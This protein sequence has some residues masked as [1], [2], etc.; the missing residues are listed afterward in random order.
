R[1]DLGRLAV[2]AARWQ[3]K[4]QARRNGFGKLRGDEPVLVLKAGPS[5]LTERGGDRRLEIGRHGDRRAKRSGE[6]TD[7]LSGLLVIERGV[8]QHCGQLGSGDLKLALQHLLVLA[9]RRGRR[10]RLDKVTSGSVQ[11]D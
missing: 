10:A 11:L 9:R 1:G 8:G 2:V 4:Q 5:P 3:D 7:R 6:W